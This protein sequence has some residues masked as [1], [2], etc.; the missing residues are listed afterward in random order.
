M[1]RPVAAEGLVRWHHPERG[2]LGP[3]EF[4]EIAERNGLIKELT[5][6][7]LDLGLRDLRSWTDQGRNLTLSLNVSVRSLL[8]RRFPEEVETLWRCTASIPMR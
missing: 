8:D 1:G 5:H 4:I 6:C 2:L 3:L 7:V